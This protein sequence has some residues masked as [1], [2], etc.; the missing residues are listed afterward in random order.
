[1]RMTWIAALF[2]PGCGGSVEG[3]ADEDPLRALV[4][5]SVVV[6]WADGSTFTWSAWVRDGSYAMS[7]EPSSCAPVGWLGFVLDDL[8]FGASHGLLPI[9]L[10]AKGAEPVRF[11]IGPDGSPEGT[12]EEREGFLAVLGDVTIPALGLTTVLVER[13]RIRFDTASA[14]VCAYGDC[15]DGQAVSVLVDT[16]SYPIGDTWHPTLR[17]SPRCLAPVPVDGAS[18]VDGRPMCWGLEATGACVDGGADPG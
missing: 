10:D 3:G 5:A 8:T 16:G 6:T 4:D 13:T 11:E 17:Y 14:V 2:L 15:A 18:R 1:M 12:T 7:P 9:P